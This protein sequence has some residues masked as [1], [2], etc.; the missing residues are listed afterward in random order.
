[1]LVKQNR[2]YFPFENGIHVA[3]KESGAVPTVFSHGSQ[4]DNK[5]DWSE[6]L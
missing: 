5:N 4:K 2:D 3:T 6:E 1:M